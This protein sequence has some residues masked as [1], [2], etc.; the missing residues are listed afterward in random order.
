[1]KAFPRPVLWC[2]LL[3]AAAPLSAGADQAER[4]KIA[5]VSSEQGDGLQNLLALAEVK[6][7]EAP[8]LRVLEREAI[9][10]VLAEQKLTL[11]GLV[12]TEQAIAVGKL[13]AVDLFAVL[14]AGVN[15]KEAAGLVVFDAR[16]GVRLWDAALPTGKPEAVVTAVLDAVRAAQRKR[17]AM[18]KLRSL[19][20]DRAQR[21]L[22]ARSRWLL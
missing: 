7:T 3:V 15:K 18:D 13:L 8:G 22:A 11:T 12:R 16:T 4:V 5:L 2:L 6:L 21:R 14:E 20:A 1:M 17:Q 10:K 9:G 19:F